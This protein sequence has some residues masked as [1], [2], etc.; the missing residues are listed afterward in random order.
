MVMCLGV[1]ASCF[2]AGLQ[3]LQPRR[4]IDIRPSLSRSVAQS[5]SAPRSGRGGRRFKSCHSDQN[6]PNKSAAFSP[7]QNSRQ[8]E[9]EL[10]NQESDAGG[11]V[12]P[13]VRGEI[14]ALRKG[15]GKPPLPMSP[16][17]PVAVGER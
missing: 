15:R 4:A 16:D 7:P 14:N 12:S 3:R 10:L 5:G 17:V 2:R 11:W 9:R 6:S 1:P 13:E 8:R